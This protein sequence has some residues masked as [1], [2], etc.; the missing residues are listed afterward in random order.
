MISILYV[1]NS[2]H[3]CEKYG[4]LNEISSTMENHTPKPAKKLLDPVRDVI[5]MKHYSRKTEKTYVAWIRRYI[6]YHSTRHP[7]DMGAPEIEPKGRDE[8]ASLGT[9]FNRMRRSLENAMKLLEG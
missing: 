6:L 8:I 7:R 4:A 3:T 5:R 1:Y 2:I 9:S